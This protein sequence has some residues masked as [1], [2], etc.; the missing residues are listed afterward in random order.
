M[1][2]VFIAIDPE[3]DTDH[4]PA[5]FVDEGSD[6]AVLVS[7]PNRCRISSSSSTRAPRA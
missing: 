3:T 4:C 1:A 6:S 5:V 2:L 7:C